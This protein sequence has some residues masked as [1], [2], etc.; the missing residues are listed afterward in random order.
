LVGSDGAIIQCCKLAIDQEEELA[1]TV[2]GCI[3]QCPKELCEVCS[4]KTCEKFLFAFLWIGCDINH[5]F[6]DMVV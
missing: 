1:E 5:L 3:W 2:R 4:T 6:T